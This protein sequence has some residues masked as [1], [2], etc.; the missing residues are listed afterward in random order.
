MCFEN[1]TYHNGCGHVGELHDQPWTLCAV[2]EGLL[3][4]R[5]PPWFGVPI[6]PPPHSPTFPTKRMSTARRFF[7]M[8]PPL[9]R[10][11]STTSTSSRRTASGPTLSR[12]STSSFA[13]AADTKI[14]E[15]VLKEV[16]CREPGSVTRRE[17]VS[18][19]MQVCKECLV[20]IQ[21]MRALVEA[22][23]RTGSVRGT[24]AFARFLEDLSESD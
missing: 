6:S 23:D 12:S 22:Y 16:R 1:H 10:H 20:A 7:S 21:D 9:N 19:D 8:G 13:S 11:R 24:R 3:R 2:A 5:Y 14:P 15:H 4:E 18:S 17:M